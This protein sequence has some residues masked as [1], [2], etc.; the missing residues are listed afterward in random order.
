MKQLNGSCECLAAA[1]IRDVFSL[2]IAAFSLPRYDSRE[3]A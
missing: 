3:G 2:Q 1:L